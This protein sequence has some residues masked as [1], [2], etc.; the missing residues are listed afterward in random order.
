[1]I[2]IGGLLLLF[3]NSTLALSA[4]GEMK[5]ILVT[6]KCMHGALC[7]YEMGIDIDPS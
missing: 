4:A 6:G 1:M 7:C 3:I 2:A 5:R